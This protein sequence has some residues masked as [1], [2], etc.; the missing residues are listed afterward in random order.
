MLEYQ[1]I[2]LLIGLL[3]RLDVFVY[4]QADEGG[5]PTAGGVELYWYLTTVLE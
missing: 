2:C 4:M 3:I 5:N 1:D